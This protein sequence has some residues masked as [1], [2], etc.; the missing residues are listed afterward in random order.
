M[1]PKVEARGLI[2]PPPSPPP[3]PS[4][5]FF[6]LMSSGLILHCL[7]GGFPHLGA[8]EHTEQPVACRSDTIRKST[9]KF[10]LSVM[11]VW[12]HKAAIFA[13][14]R[15][16]EIFSHIIKR[17]YLTKNLMGSSWNELLLVKCTISQFRLRE[18]SGKF[19]K[20]VFSG[21]HVDKETQL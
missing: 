17:S 2:D 12:L 9:V 8:R 3:I 21:K 14:L 19:W 5:N 13:I 6:R 10:E 4:C 20:W 15:P 1:V 18:N 7:L 16:S 11:G